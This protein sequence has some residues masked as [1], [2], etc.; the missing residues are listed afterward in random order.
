MRISV[1]I[2]TYNRGH[3]ISKTLDS[4]ISQ[5]ISKEQY[6]III[7]DNNS[8]DNTQILLQEYKRKYGDFIKIH[9][10]INQG[11]HYARNSASK[12]ANGNILYFTDDDMIADFNLL[13]QILKPFDMDNLMGAVSGKIVPLWEVPPPKWVELLC[14]N[15]LLSLNDMG[16]ELIIS[17]NDMGVFSCHEAIKKEVFFKTGGFNPE[18]TKGK[19]IGDGETGLNIKIKNLGYKFAYNGKSKIQ[20]IIPQSRM[21]QLYLNKRL[22]NQGNCDVYTEYKHLKLTNFQL[23]K[24]LITCLYSIVKC[25]ISTSEII[26]KNYVKRQINRTD[27]NIN[28]RIQR[29][30]INYHKS[31]FFYY[32]K[33]IYSK[34]WRELVLKDNWLV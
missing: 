32:L 21:T 19:W 15:Y 10:E 4:F 26:L 20:H 8:N 29:A 33:L 17:E 6:E 14:K 7:S 11:V 22:A 1:I 9:K 25:T 3:Y 18:N 16:D 34:K 13:E 2:P 23:I 31:K 27:T 30:L 24:K 5:S 28:W 12:I